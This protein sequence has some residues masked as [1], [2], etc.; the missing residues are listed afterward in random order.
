MNNMFEMAAGSVVGKEHLRTGKN[1]QDAYCYRSLPAGIIAVVCDGCSSGA[2]SEVGAKLGAQLVTD[3]IYEQLAG[4]PSALHTE[5]F[6]EQV[7]QAALLQLSKLTAI[8][9]SDL[10]CIVRDYLLFTVVGV[11]VT[12]IETVLFAIGDGVIALNDQV[13]PLPSFPNN[14]PPY[15]GYGLISSAVAGLTLE[16]LKIQ[17]HHCVPTHSVQS[18]LIGTDG[19]QD[20]I[21]AANQSLPGKPELVGGI[22]QFWQNDRYFKNPDCIRRRLT[23]MNHTLTKP[24]WEA[25]WLHQEGGLLPDDTTM[26]VIRRKDK[27]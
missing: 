8:L 22:S 26:V 1:N 7:R 12:P 14:A 13:I 5:A 19:V 10:V 21:A 25:R 2:H 27:G 6:W 9:G 18:I 3:V 11:V 16:D 4:H 23:Q 15:L 17:V 24:D 20:A